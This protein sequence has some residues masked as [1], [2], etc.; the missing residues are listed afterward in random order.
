MND[1][2][3]L[4]QKILDYHRKDYAADKQVL[5]FTCHPGHAE[6]LDGNQMGL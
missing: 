5:I 6:M 2:S 3:A 1:F 4:Q